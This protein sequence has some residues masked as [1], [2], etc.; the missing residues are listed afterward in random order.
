VDDIKGFHVEQKVFDDIAKQL[1]DKYGQETSL[2]GG[3]S[4]DGT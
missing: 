4:R 2:T 3:T 1:N